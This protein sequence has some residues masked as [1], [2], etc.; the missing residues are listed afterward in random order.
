MSLASHVQPLVRPLVLLNHDQNMVVCA[1]EILV[2][3][4]EPSAAS[5]AAAGDY[6]SA[7]TA[8]TVPPQ[9]AAQIAQLHLTDAR[10]K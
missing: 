9:T 5:I 7:R 3:A 10:I 6:K 4:S 8:T 2:Q 1:Y